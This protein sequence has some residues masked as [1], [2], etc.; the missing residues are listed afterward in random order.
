MC[1]TQRTEKPLFLYVRCRRSAGTALS[2]SF[3]GTLH[4][5]SKLRHEAFHFLSRALG[6]SSEVS[7]DP[8]V[9][10]PAASAYGPVPCGRDSRRPSEAGNA[11]CRGIYV[12]GGG[13]ETSR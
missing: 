11:R 13:D 3:S 1:Q 4:S 2:V 6:L 7:L 9:G 5:T 8:R 12:G 10:V